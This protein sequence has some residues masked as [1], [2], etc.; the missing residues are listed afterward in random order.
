MECS[1]YNIQG[2]TPIYAWLE[3][4]PFF[5][6]LTEV[7]PQKHCTID[8]LYIRPIQSLQNLEISKT[9]H[10]FYVIYTTI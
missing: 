9:F 5:D 4:L 6:I 2:T 7:H 10:K 8:A 1:Q 3:R